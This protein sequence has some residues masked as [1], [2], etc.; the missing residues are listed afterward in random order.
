MGA[1]GVSRQGVKV[2]R[3]LLVVCGMVL[4]CSAVSGDAAQD[5]NLE[6]R[7]SPSWRILSNSGR[8]TQE[9]K[10][11]TF[12]D[13]GW[14][15][16]EL[17]CDSAA[18]CQEVVLAGDVQW[19]YLR[20]ELEVA[21]PTRIKG[22]TVEISCEGPFTA[23]LNGVEMLSSPRP[24]L[25]K[26]TP[27]GRPRSVALDVSGFV[28]EL[29]AGSNLIG[30]EAKL[31]PAARFPFVV[32]PLIRVVLTTQ[33]TEIAPFHDSRRMQPRAGGTSLPNLQTTEVTAPR[34]VILLV[35][36]GWGDM[37]IQATNQYTGAVP[38]YQTSPAWTQ[39]WMSTF[40]TGGAY[41]AARTWSELLFP[42][43]GTTDSAASMTAMTRGIKTS[44]GRIGVDAA[45]LSP[46]AGI[47]ELA[48]AHGLAVGVVTTVP[49]SHA[50]PGAFAAHN[51]SRANTFA[52][53]D[54]LFFADP[55]TTGTL[56]VD[57]RYDGGFGPRVAPPE[58]IIGGRSPAYLATAAH[59]RLVTES[60][61]PGKHV[62]VDGVA[63]RDGGNDLLW[64]A[65]DP[66]CRRLA[67]LF[68]YVALSAAAPDGGYRLETPA[69]AQSTTAALTVLQRNPAGFVL[70][71]EGGA[72]DWAGHANDMDWMVGELR[73]FN[74]AVARVVDWV[75]SFANASRW[76]NTLVLVTGD[77][78][79]GYLTRG[80]AVFPDQELAPDAVT[81][82]TLPLE[83]VDLASGQRA[84]WVDSAPA[85]DMID[86]GETVYWSWHTS[87][88]SNVLI[89]LFARGVGAELLTLLATESDSVRGPYVDNT[90]LFPVMAAVVRSGPTIFNDGFESGSTAQW[91]LVVP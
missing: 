39:L 6:I 53:A 86:A 91:S 79:T 36:D 44:N 78:E 64:A 7:T 19:L 65:F 76:S 89:P 33:N 18:S 90:V 12:D 8:L 52:I 3:R 14:A 71:V 51:L 27:D 31:T 54:E 59:D 11:P 75:D 25:G 74:Q 77:H 87:G 55:N 21:D 38:D 34:F 26:L 10:D 66:S 17:T 30:V 28:H 63:G 69:L 24:M 35:C 85:N 32:L 68:D 42:L 50:T 20:H 56:V 57:P 58:V 84:S 4:P 5:V 82:D 37:H 29:V 67:G 70:M 81:D 13:A 45:G 47:V 40:P 88:H 62:L 16:R 61:L 60:G 73:D 43:E 1:D 49:I 46:L 80:A 15:V 23:Y 22:M 48:R 72:V 41:D 9:W 83:K 2:L